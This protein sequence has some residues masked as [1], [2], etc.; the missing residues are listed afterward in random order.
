MKSAH[1]ILILLIEEIPARFKKIFWKIFTGLT[2]IEHIA[3]N[4]DHNKETQEYRPQSRSPPS[5]DATESRS[6]T[7]FEITARSL[8][9]SGF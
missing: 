3:Y 4:S 8:N 6:P 7:T 2:P 9:S 5:M 1:S